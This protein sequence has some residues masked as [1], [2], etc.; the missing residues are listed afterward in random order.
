MSDAA[1]RPAPLKVSCPRV[2]GSVCIHTAAR[3]RQD[4]VEPAFEV[5]GPRIA[6]SRQPAKPT[7]S[8]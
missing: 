2:D 7:N 6:G 8:A 3:W 5:G 4:D 1:T